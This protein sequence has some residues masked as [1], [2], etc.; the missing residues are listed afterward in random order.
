M[1]SLAILILVGASLV[2]LVTRKDPF[3]STSTR[4][5]KTTLSSYYSQKLNWQ[6]C[7]GSFTCATYQVPIDYENLSVG[8]FDIAVMRHS[9]ANAQSNLVINP[10]GPGG[11]GVDYAYSYASS[12]TPEVIDKFNLI[13][14]DPR[15][16]G[17]SAPIK[18][19]SNS[20][21]DQF[22][23]QDSYP[24]SDADLAKLKAENEAFAKSCESKNR[25]LSFYSTANTA[26]DMDILRALIG[27][28]KLNF[29]GKS[30]GTYL[31]AL[32]AQLFPNN[33]GRFVL[34][35]AVDPT[36]NSADQSVQQA[37]GF[38]SAFKDFATDCM[39]LA[40]CIF[41][42]DPVKELQQKLDELR[43]NPVTVGNRKVTESLAMYG[44]A[45]G[46]Y[47]RAS[48]WPALRGALKDLYAGN[49]KTILQLSDVYTGR[50][51]NGNYPTN[52]AESLS[53]ISCND[54]PPTSSVKLNGLNSD[55]LFGKYVAYSDLDCNYLPHGK[56]ELIS[57][58]IDVKNATLVIGTTNDPATPYQWAEKL[59]KVISNSVLLTLESDGHTGYNRGS[60]CIDQ[61]VEKYL[62]SGVIPA[63]DTRCRY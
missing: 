23:S 4:A 57:S 12:F 16:V 34:D 59:S 37:I 3:K 52:E 58:K 63:G 32:Y 8:K 29:L 51:A 62:I 40:D 14:F 6:S 17:R 26:R 45:F 36:L 35:G 39:K 53:I 30:Y 19:L 24:T 27:D 56:Y 10:G 15:G 50:D 43:A 11:S 44:V 7:Y 28:Q 49:G 25:F 41:Q 60:T 38:D 21:T 54:F 20:E 33:V 46:L 9:G 42:S 31:G 61:V 47:D 2:N 13:G 1:A 18:C 5:T 55:S 48:G 22:Y